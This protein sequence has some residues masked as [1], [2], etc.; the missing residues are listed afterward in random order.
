MP[1]SQQKQYYIKITQ[2]NFE[3]LIRNSIEL[4]AMIHGSGSLFRWMLF[5]QP[6]SQQNRRNNR[7][8]SKRD[9]ASKRG[10]LGALYA[11]IERQR[12][13]I[14]PFDATPFVGIASIGIASI[15]I[16]S[17]YHDSLHTTLATSANMAIKRKCYKTG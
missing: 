9:H 8:H 16:V 4:E 17:H 3:A 7:R 6:T 5:R 10:A 15:G 11:C 14:V 12:L 1:P 13:T 2:L